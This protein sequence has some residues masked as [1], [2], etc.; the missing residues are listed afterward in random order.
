[1]PGKASVWGAP[2]RRDNLSRDLPPVDEHRP[3]FRWSEGSRQ[4]GRVGRRGA[5]LCSH[6]HC[7]GADRR[8]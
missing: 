2:D 1:M 5:A 7:V 3:R 8:L 4:G 6:C